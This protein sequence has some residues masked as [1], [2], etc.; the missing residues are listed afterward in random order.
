[1]KRVLVITGPT[2][3]G[4]TALAVSLAQALGTEVIGA[5]S[6]Q[7]YR[8]LD[9]GTA[10]PTAA[11]MQGIVHHGIDICAPQESFSVQRY[12]SYADAILTDL[13]AEGK[14]PILAGG[15]G[16]YIDALIRGN[17]FPPFSGEIR[18]QL[19]ARLEAEGIEVLYAELMQVDPERAQKLALA[20]QKRILR[21]LEVYWETGDTITNHDLR[22]QLQP[23]KYDACTFVLQYADRAD[24]YARIDQRVDEML[25]EGLLQEIEALLA[26]GLSP[27]STAMQAIGYKELVPVLHGACALADAVALMKQRSRNYAK[28][29]LTWHRRNPHAIPIIWN[30]TPDIKGATEQILCTLG[31]DR[32]S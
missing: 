28:R 3:S 24:L 6:M 4:K 26:Q 14:T 20:D 13:L 25:Q 11:E 29:Q 12:V 1:M 30:K 2:A 10:K 31:K 17:D 9:I 22:T 32:H 8:G 21:A 16:Q 15:T 19:S 27:E 5:D 7:I 23:P 18:A